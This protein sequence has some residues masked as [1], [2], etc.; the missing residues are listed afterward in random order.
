[1]PD[2][3]PDEEFGGNSLMKRAIVLL[4]ILMAVAGLPACAIDEGPDRPVK[5]YE[6]VAAGDIRQVH[7]SGSASSVVIQRSES[8]DLEFYNGDLD[9]AHTYTVRCD[10]DGDTLNVEL[11]M[12]NPKNDNDVLGSPMICIPGKEFEMIEVAGDFRQV[13][14]DTIH[15]DVLIH[16]NDSRVILDLE[17]DRL[18]HDITLAGS[19]TDTFRSV[20][21]Y[22][23]RVPDGVTLELDTV[24]GGSISDPDG[25]LKEEGLEAGSGR[26]VISVDHAQEISLY[27][28][29]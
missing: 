13:S 20:A 1:M 12:E 17:A 15:S 21:V 5:M 16:A 25:I 19:G 26:P 3:V 11:V 27:R 22:F 14:L 23:D 10:R 24:E 28:E 8:E 29:G 2:K 6:D 9:P 7:I 4:A 18:D